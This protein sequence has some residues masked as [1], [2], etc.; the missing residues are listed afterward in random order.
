MV[1]TVG[2]H[3]NGVREERL[4]SLVKRLS[5]ALKTYKIDKIDKIDKTYERK[6][7]VLTI[8]YKRF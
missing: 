2:W 8:L 4:K 7:R 3:V 5:E 6:Q 1:V